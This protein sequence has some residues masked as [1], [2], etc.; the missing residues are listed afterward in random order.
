MGTLTHEE[1]S[2]LYE[3]AAEPSA[4]LVE[5]DRS[6]RDPL[7]R[8]AKSTASVKLGGFTPAQMKRRRRE[9]RSGCDDQRVAPMDAKRMRRDGI[10]HSLLATR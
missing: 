6:G 9:A 5:L 1:P 4:Y 10:R 8:R 3:S 7:L 2:A